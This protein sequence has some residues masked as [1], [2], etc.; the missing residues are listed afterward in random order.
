MLRELDRKMDGLQKNRYQNDLN[1]YKRAVNQQKNDKN[2]I[3]SLHKPFTE[4][5]AKGKAHKQYEFG[6]KVGVIT[7]GSEGKK[8]V[9]AINHLNV[10]K[11]LKMRELINVKN[12]KKRANN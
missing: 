10:I 11:L 6:N 9:L 3:Y 2:K 8:I 5:I 4:C 7:G 12:T 1:L